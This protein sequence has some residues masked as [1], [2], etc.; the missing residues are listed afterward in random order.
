MPPSSALILDMG[1]VLVFFDHHRACR[2]LAALGQPGTTEDDVFDLLFHQPLERH[3]DCGEI[4]TTTL[5]AALREAFGIT[6]ADE[7]IANA[8]ADIFEPNEALVAELPGLRLRFDRLVLASNTNELHI[9]RVRALIPDTLAL[10]D[11]HV[12]SFEVGCRK[13]AEEFFRRAIAAAG[14]RASEC[15]YIDDRED[16]VA[17]AQALGMNAVVYGRGATSWPQGIMPTSQRL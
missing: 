11:E 17:A 4:T 14:G 10:F 5:L 8:W 1:N 16:F 7:S 13:P 2:R 9:G 15:V 3:Y 12:L 6:A